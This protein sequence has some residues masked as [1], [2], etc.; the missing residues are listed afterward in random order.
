MR[1]T[2]EICLILV[3]MTVCLAVM[4]AKTTSQGAAMFVDFRKGTEDLAHPRRLLRLD[5]ARLID[6]GLLEF[7]YQPTHQP[8]VFF[9]L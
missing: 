7:S 4:G 5:G 3:V 2:R 8:F 6:S 1:K 9:R